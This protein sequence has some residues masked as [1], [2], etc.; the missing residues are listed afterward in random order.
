MKTQY[1]Y[2]NNNV[3]REKKKEWQ[4]LIWFKLLKCWPLNFKHFKC[5]F[6]KF[7]WKLKWLLS[8]GRHV[9]CPRD[10][11]WPTLAFNAIYHSFDTCTRFDAIFISRLYVYILHFITFLWKVWCDRCNDTIGQLQCFKFNWECQPAEAIFV[12]HRLSRYSKRQKLV[13][14]AS[15]RA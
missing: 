4:K 1:F 5:E 7:G 12:Y 9:R 15:Q 10:N 6:S 14:E 3:V 2:M 8:R 11:P 13:I